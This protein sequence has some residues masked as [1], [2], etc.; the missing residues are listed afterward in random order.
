VIGSPDL[1]LD[2]RRGAGVLAAAVLASGIAFLDG[3]VVNA[4]LPS[5]ADELV[6]SLADL[7]WVISAY[8]LTL[9]AFLVLGGS[10][11]DHYGRRRVLVWGLLGFAATS[12]LCG[13]APNTEVLV[14]GRSLQGVAGA[15]M[16]PGSLAIVQAS[17]RT[18]DRGRAIGMW[19]GLSGVSV[20]LGP[21]LG[22]WLIDSLSWRLVFFVNVPLVAVTVLLAIRFVPE[23]RDPTASGGIDWLGGAV[24]VVGLGA[25]VYALIQ[26]PSGGWSASTIA[27]G[28]VGVVALVLFPVV[29]RRVDHPMVPLTMFRSRQFS[30]ANAVTLLVYAALSGVFF[31][32]VVHLQT[33]MGYSALE[34]GASLLPVTACLLVLSP[35]AGALSQR[36]GPRIPMTVGP[37]IAGSGMALLALAEP[38]RSYW[39]AVLPGAIVLGLGLSVTV[40]PLTTAVLAAAGDEHAGIGSAINNAVSRVASLVAI[41]ILP[42]AAGLTTSGDSLDLVDGFD[43]AMVISGVTCALGGLV[44]AALIRTGT[45]TRIVR[46]ADVTIPC[47][48]GLIEEEPSADAA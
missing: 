18:V 23:T 39:V 10:L 32:L 48:P 12:A 42:V 38:G 7:Q 19:S 28:L 21:F 9:G 2:S 40:A 27:L 6:A 15:L 47:P 20:A 22:G 8:L 44:A 33:D 41:A 4:A 5:I 29:E 25:G 16:V 14:A 1:R 35:R 43:K 30:G 45:P 26:A 34:A 13:I 3:T 24:L 11:G 36:T 46:R 31:L 17:F 37:L